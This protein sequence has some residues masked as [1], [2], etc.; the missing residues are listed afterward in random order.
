M[1][2]TT[3]T[4]ALFAVALLSLL[5]FAGL[6]WAGAEARILGTV[7][8]PDGKPIAAAKVVITNPKVASFR[9]EVTTDEAG[10]FKLLLADSTYSYKYTV[11]APGMPETSWDKKAPIGTTQEFE[12]RLAA[13]PSTAQGAPTQAPARETERARSARS[14]PRPAR[15]HCAT[16]KMRIATGN[17]SSD[18]TGRAG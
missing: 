5:G 4:A 9:R 8:G 13:A 1:S 6:A 3:R 17:G 16:G 12:F 11:S 15:N 10:Q 2:R 18:K 7:L 14:I